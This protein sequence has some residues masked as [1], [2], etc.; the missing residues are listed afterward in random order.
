MD[1][2]YIVVGL[3]NLGKQ[4]DNTR[5]NIG[6]D[7]INHLAKKLS[8]DVNKLKFKAYIGEGRVGSK[9]VVLVKPQTYM[10]L[11]G[12]SVREIIDWYKIDL[13]KLIVIYD[14]V[15][16]DFAKV[17]VRPK[18]SSGTHNGMRSIIH[19]IQSDEFPRIRMGIGRPPARFKLADFVLGK[20]TKEEQKDMD[21]SKKH[22]GKCVESIISDGVDAT[23][24]KFNKKSD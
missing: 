18:G 15:D 6:F 11:S 10:N 19:Q 13:D 21:E 1:N 20:F 5:H 24:N 22:A 9:K 8:I 4:Y 14:D 12:E 7:V 2:V 23:M 16:I 17:R 3:G